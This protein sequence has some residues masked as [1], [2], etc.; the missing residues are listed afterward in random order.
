LP[1][2][3]TTVL[4]EALGLFDHHFRD[5]DV[6]HGGFVEGG[7]DHLALDRARH[8]GDF[9]GP[10]VDQQHDQE[11][12]GVIGGDRVRDVLHHHRFAGARL[13]HDQRAL[14]FAERRDQIDDAGGEVFL[15]SRVAQFED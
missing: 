6:A 3:G 10:L 7:A 14:A 2:D 12:F 5:L 9:L 8:V 4:D 11:H 15:R 13:R 1:D